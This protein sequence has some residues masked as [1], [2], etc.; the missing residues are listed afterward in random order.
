MIIHQSLKMLH[1]YL[2]Y[3][4]KTN[5]NKII[6]VKKKKDYLTISLK[7]VQPI[8]IKTFLIFFSRVLF[9]FIH[10]VVHIF[11]HL[12]FRLSLLEYQH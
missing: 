8:T 12:T 11:N 1:E 7:I 10:F 6:N 5:Y 3:R 2:S 9:N 4:S